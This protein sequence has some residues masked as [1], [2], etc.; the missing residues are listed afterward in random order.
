VDIDGGV[1]AAL[2]AWDGGDGTPVAVHCGG[3][4][5]EEEAPPTEGRDTPPLSDRLLLDL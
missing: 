2:A 4:P 1:A 5:G 3:A